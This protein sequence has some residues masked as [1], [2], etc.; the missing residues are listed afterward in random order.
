MAKI[1]MIIA[2][3]RFRDEELFVTKEELEKAGHEIVIA[4]SVKGICPGS[5]GGFATATLML[6]EVQA[7]DYDAVVF[8]GGGGSKLLYANEEALRIAKEMHRKKTVVAAICLAPVILANAGI[9]NG[10]NATVA[11]TEAKTI[12]SKGANIPNR[13]LL[14]M[15][16]L[17]PAMPP[18]VQDCLGRKLTNY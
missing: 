1:V 7:S 17:L 14:W 2:P 4:S 18:R 9:L 15:A 10:K 5:R 12:E 8:V 3:E 6:N 16:I 11:G 13:G